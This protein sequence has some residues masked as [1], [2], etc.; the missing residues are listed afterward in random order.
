MLKVWTNSFQ[1]VLE[2]VLF[3]AWSIPP[4]AHSWL[5]CRSPTRVSTMFILSEGKILFELT[6]ISNNVKV[7]YF[8]FVGEVEKFG[9][10]RV[11]PHE[12]DSSPKFESH[13]EIFLRDGCACS[14]RVKFDLRN[15]HRTH[16]TDI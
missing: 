16:L 11:I 4:T 1:E 9:P 6:C 13:L 14:A 5:L 3:G 8:D 12:W 10:S 7:W 2:A 15:V